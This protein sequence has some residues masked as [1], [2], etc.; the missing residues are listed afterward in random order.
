M[1][2]GRPVYLQYKCPK[3]T[4][5]SPIVSFL[6]KSGFNNVYA[7]LRSYYGKDLNAEQQ[8]K[9]LLDLYNKGLQVAK[10]KGGTIFSHFQSRTL[11]EYKATMHG[12][13]WMIVIK[14]LPLYYISELEVRRFSEFKATII[15]RRICKE[16]Y[17]TKGAV[18]YDGWTCN[19]MHY[20]AL[21]AL[22]CTKK[23][24]IESRRKVVR[25]TP[26][27]TLLAMSLMGQLEDD[28]VLD[29]TNNET[30]TFNAETHAH[31]FNEI[32]PI[33][34]QDFASWCVCLIADNCSTNKKTASKLGK[35]FVGCNSHKL[36]LEVNHM[37]DRH[38]Q[39][40]QTID[41]VHGTMKDAKKLRNAALLRN[42][43]D[44]SP[45][46][47]NTTRRSGKLHML[48]RFIRIREDLL[49]VHNSSEGDLL[50]D[51]SV[52]LATRAQKFSKMLAE[53]D[54]VTKSL[55]TRGHTLA[56]CRDDLD[57]LLETVMEQRNI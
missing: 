9:V 6:D 52:Q 38:S 15:E 19:A 28:T 42:L 10:Q 51:A 17:G 33:F 36:N 50:I 57:V 37:A 1:D 34:G 13:I 25:F 43:T 23:T 27:L 31:F 7:H 54:I 47:H 48:K 22:Y 16:L 39:G 14:S 12:Y 35:R 30:T 2:F 46:M 53:L 45:R 11:Y 5:V 29:E 3:A 4:C 21:I 26:R 44:L 8:D 55:Q 40:K 32:F 41:S 20:I 18:L 24:S 56:Q 49:D